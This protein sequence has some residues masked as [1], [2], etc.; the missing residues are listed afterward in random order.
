MTLIFCLQ[1]TLKRQP[2][3][4][5]TSLIFELLHTEKKFTEMLKNDLQLKFMEPMRTF[6]S[7]SDIQI[8]FPKIKVC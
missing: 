4:K 8:I 3:H 7:E 2:T 5:K 6:L 1:Q